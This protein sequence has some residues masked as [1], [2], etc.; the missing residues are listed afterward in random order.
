MA[1]RPQVKTNNGMIDFPLDAETVKGK[2]ILEQ[3][4]PV[5]SIY[6]SVNSTSPASLFG[7]T[8]EQ[9]NGLTKLW[10]NPSPNSSFTNRNAIP[11]NGMNNYKYI[12]IA[13]SYYYYDYQTPKYLKFENISGSSLIGDTNIPNDYANRKF[14]LNKTNQTITFGICNACKTNVSSIYTE[15]YLVIPLA[16][17]GTN[18]LGNDEIQYIWKRTA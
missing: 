11:L 6:M 14:T 4:Y 16:I 15:D 13:F 3:T 2:T 9:I 17:Y 7:G 1:Y 10:E 8:W 12:V 18:E 5:G